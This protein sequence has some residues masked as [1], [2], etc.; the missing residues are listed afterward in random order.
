MTVSFVARSKWLRCF[1][2]GGLGDV[3]VSALN[4]E[5]TVALITAL[6]PLLIAGAEL[7][8]V[9]V[10]PPST[11]AATSPDGGC[12]GTRAC[13][14][15]SHR[16]LREGSAGRPVHVGVKK[17]GAGFPDDAPRVFM[18]TPA[19]AATGTSSISIA[20]SSGR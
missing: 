13:T 9:P 6:R 20:C 18:A 4:E 7:A 15:A 19:A 17:L 1:T 5:R 10:M 14:R 3:R 16:T 8:D 11:V 2:H 12:A